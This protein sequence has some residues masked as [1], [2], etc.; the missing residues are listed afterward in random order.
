LERRRKE[1]MGRESL[2]CKMKVCLTDDSQTNAKPFGV[3]MKDG[4]KEERKKADEGR[5]GA[6]KEGQKDGSEK[7]KS[8][9]GANS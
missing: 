6:K 2:T 3:V 8:M 7:G 5:K 4:K 9:K 1:R